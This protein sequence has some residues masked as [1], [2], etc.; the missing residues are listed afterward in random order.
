MDETV[1]EI[2]RIRRSLPAR[3]RTEEVEAAMTVVANAEKE[4]ASRLAAA[5]AAARQ[6]KVSDVPE[7]LLTVVEEMQ[8]SV[9]SFQCKEQ[10]RDALRLV[11]LENLHSLFDHL[12]QRASDCVS[13][14]NNNNRNKKSSGPSNKAQWASPKNSASVSSG[15]LKKPPVKPSQLFS[16]D[17]SYL[18]KAKSIGHSIS[19]KQQI[20]DSSLKPA[21]TSGNPT[22]VCFV[23]IFS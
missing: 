5:A 19:F 14:S 1:E 6:S 23:S 7:E 16:K 10:K 4:E 2:M 22:N 17:D 8:K 3:P 12:I 11:D 15:L 9:V 18:N 20:L 21:S 13:N